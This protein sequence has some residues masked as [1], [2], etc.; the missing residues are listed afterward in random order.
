MG[1]KHDGG[2]KNFELI[3]VPGKLYVVRICNMGNCVQSCTTH[4]QDM[5]PLSQY[6]SRLRSFV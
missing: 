5:N 4:N 1:Y 6:L 2:K 3:A